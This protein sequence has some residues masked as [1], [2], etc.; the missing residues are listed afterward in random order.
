MVFPTV[1]GG[2]GTTPKITFPEQ[3]PSSTLGVKVL[4]E[5]SGPAV[6]SGNLLIANYVGQIWNGKVFDSSFARKQPAGFGIGVGQVI[7]G[8]DKGL[9]GKHL[10]S[11]VLLV[12]PPDEGYGKSGSSDGSIKGTDTIVFVVDLLKQYSKDAAGSK[13]AV[14]QDVSTAPVTVSGALGS[15]PTIKIAKGA[16]APTKEQTTVL[17]KADGPATKAGLVVLQY[18]AVV[19]SSGA[20]AD[21]TWQ[22]GT[23]AAIPIGVSGQQATFDTLV[24]IPVGSRVLIVAPV[25]TQSGSSE[26]VAAVVDIVAQVSS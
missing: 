26:T 10:G 1:K 13:T 11:R 17:A 20:V 16:K 14:K 8:W 4:S 9:V 12:V 5:G 21:S 19:F 6:Q 18:E 24:G 25:Q 2:F 22:T 3:K 7:S 15:R 23:P